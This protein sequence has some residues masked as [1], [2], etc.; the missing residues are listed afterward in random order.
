MLREHRKTIKNAGHILW[1]AF[2]LAYFFVQLA[3]SVE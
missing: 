1:G 2:L 3:M